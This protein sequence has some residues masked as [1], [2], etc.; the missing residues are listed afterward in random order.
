M[1]LEITHT[2]EYTYSAPVHYALLQA[3][4]TPKVRKGVTIA[5][6]QLAVAGGQ[7]ELAFQDH[8]NNTVHLIGIE[9]GAERIEITTSGIIETSSQ[10]GVVGKHCDVT[11]LWYF[12]RTT[13]LTKPGPR[14]RKLTKMIDVET[15]TDIERLHELSDLVR[16]EVSYETGKTDTLT[17]AETA[18]ENGHGVCQDHAHIFLTAAR[19]LGYPA[20]YVSGYLLLAEQSIQEASHAWAEAL[21]PDLGWVGFD[22][23]NGYSPDERYVALATG[24]DYLEA[25]PLSGIRL[26]TSEESMVVSL[27]IQQ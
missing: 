11:P 26:G 18:L 23:S 3:R 13:D 22:V 25:S 15:G 20:R 24:L 12:K 6:W 14:S 5:D 9:Q 4:L 27:Q 8:N 17:T 10:S 2:T 7:S 21:V 1:R 16:G 19:L